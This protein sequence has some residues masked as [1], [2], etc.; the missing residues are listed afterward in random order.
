M[1]MSSLYVFVISLVI[2]LNGY[3]KLAYLYTMILQP[4]SALKEHYLH[5]KQ[6]S[7]YDYEHPDILA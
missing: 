3:L 4:E 5:E 1:P 7:C 6:D 2:I